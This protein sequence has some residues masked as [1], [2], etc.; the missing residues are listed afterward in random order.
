MRLIDAM[1]D[2]NQQKFIIEFE[3]RVKQPVI[4]NPY[5]LNKT[6]WIK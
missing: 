1:P 3:I 4:N 6:F 5:I 2:M